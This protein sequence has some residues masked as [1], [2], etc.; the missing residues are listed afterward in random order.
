V[1]AA[2]A[3]ATEPDTGR[4]PRLLRLVQPTLVTIGVLV[5]ALV[6]LAMADNLYLQT[7]A[8]LTLLLVRPQG[9]A[10]SRLREDV[11]A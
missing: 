3:V 4:R 11:A 7:V 8:I 1:T 2:R 5:L 10:G 6:P 9:I